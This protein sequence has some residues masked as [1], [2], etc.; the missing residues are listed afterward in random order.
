[1]HASRW[2]TF[3]LL[4]AQKLQQAKTC[5][6][7]LQPK[8]FQWVHHIYLLALCY[9][10]YV[11]HDICVIYTS[12]WKCLCY[13]LQWK[14]N[15]LYSSHELDAQCSF[16]CIIKLDPLW[17]RLWCLWLDECFG[18][19]VSPYVL[20]HGKLSTRSSSHLVDIM[21]FCLWMLIMLK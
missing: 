17:L 8:L 15:W 4:L 3:S 13:W 2:S 10:E 14:K 7:H 11:H 19:E 12:E 6:Q 20:S 21:C 1:M 18:L 9:S 5:F 16:I